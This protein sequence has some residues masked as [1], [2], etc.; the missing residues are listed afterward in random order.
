MVTTSRGILYPSTSD[1]ITPLANHFANLATTTN[2]ALDNLDNATTYFIGTD[3]QRIALTAPKLRK[4]I[5]W[6]TTDTDSTW[7]YD[8]TNWIINESGL[9]LVQPQSVTGGTV[10][11]GKVTPTTGQTTVTIN[12][13]FSSRFRSYKVIA[14][15]NFSSLAGITVQ[16]CSTGTPS[17][18]GYYTQYAY[19]SGSGVAASYVPNTSSLSLAT[20]GGLGASHEITL[21]K[22][23]LALDTYFSTT[24]FAPTAGMWTASGFHQPTT[25]YDGLRITTT[26]GTFSAGNIAVYGLL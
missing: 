3:A 2:T 15:L 14:D 23:G 5:T 18:T 4:G 6:R 24:G 19:A 13:V 12:G 26:A 7:L 17:T 8:G 1:A 10:T 25:A 9:V 22:P 11:A 21:Q 16:L 20:Y